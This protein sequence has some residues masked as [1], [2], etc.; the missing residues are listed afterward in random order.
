MRRQVR[1]RL[2]APPGPALIYK[3]AV[4]LGADFECAVWLGA[5]IFAPSCTAQ[6][7]MRQ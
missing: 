6:Q 7:F 3:C 2:I 4:W 5:V 1:R